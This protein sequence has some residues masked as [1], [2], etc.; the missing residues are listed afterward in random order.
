M[1]KWIA[2]YLNKW[3]YYYCYGCPD[4]KG[5]CMSQESQDCFHFDLNPSSAAIDGGITLLTVPSVPCLCRVQNV[6]QSSAYY[7]LLKWSVQRDT[8]SSLLFTDWVLS[9]DI[10]LISIL[11]SARHLIINYFFKAQLM[12][13]NLF[14]PGP[15]TF[16][17]Q[18]RLNK[19]FLPWQYLVKTHHPALT[20]EAL[21]FWKPE[22]SGQ[23]S[24]IVSFCLIIEI[25]SKLIR[26]YHEQREPL[27]CVLWAL[28]QWSFF[29][30]V[31]M[32]L[33]YYLW[34]Y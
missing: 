12:I 28:K 2:T 4:A 15:S 8:K 30:S 18:N 10:V 13:P 1:E 11:L 20:T 19:H 23:S 7:E 6:Q 9:P 17:T 31:A 32:G 24:I 16:A 22:L 26:Q 25:E 21:N 29:F 3:S 5:P 14:P 27:I 34:T 33:R